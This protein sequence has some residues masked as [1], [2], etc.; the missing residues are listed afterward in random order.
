MNA[1]IICTIADLPGT[2]PGNWPGDMAVCRLHGDPDRS[3]NNIYAVQAGY[4][5][6]QA[7]KWL[8]TP[9][10][11]CGI[12]VSLDDLVSHATAWLSDE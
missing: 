12:A 7:G 9:A 3:P 6:A 8:L 10:I 11:P 2:L 4:P 1:E 5:L